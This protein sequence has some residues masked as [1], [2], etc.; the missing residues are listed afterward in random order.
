MPP[1][2]NR[3]KMASPHGSSQPKFDPS[4]WLLRR[5]T[6]VD[7]DS[8]ASQHDLRQKVRRPLPLSPLGVLTHEVSRSTDTMSKDCRGQKYEFVARLGTGIHSTGIEMTEHH[9]F[10]PL[11]PCLCRCAQSADGIQTRLF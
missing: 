1:R 8:V 2:N 10:C 6:D 3:G 5:V 9:S 11:P 4:A 7:D